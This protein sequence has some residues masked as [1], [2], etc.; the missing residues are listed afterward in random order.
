MPNIKRL[1]D[2]S[3]YK[4]VLPY[5]SE[6]FGVYQPLIGWKS[7]RKVVRIGAGV[8]L[9]QGTLI[10]RL[11][12]FFRNTAPIG[13]NVDCAVSWPGMQPAGFIGTS[14]PSDQSFVVAGGRGEAGDDGSAGH[15]GCLAAGGERGH[16]GRGAGVG[17]GTLE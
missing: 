8:Q 14:A 11:S 15:D 2:L 4:G 16:A 1:I 6:L 17:A 9:E 5:D 13:I 3:S 7:R 12:Q 10:G